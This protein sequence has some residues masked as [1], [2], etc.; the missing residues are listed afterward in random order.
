ML[1]HTCKK[2][3]YIEVGVVCHQAVVREISRTIQ[4]NIGESLPGGSI[5]LRK[6]MPHWNWR[7]I[8]NASYHY[9]NDNS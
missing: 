8:Q 6:E 7:I 1:Q 2:T 3:N 9:Y 5:L 4:D